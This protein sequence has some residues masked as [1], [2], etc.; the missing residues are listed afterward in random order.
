MLMVAKSPTSE[1]DPKAYAGVGATQKP[2]LASA[3]YE[4]P[5]YLIKGL[6]YYQDLRQYTPYYWEDRIRFELKSKSYLWEKGYFP[7][8]QKKRLQRGKKRTIIKADKFRQEHKTDSRYSVRYLGFYRN[9]AS[10]GR[11]SIVGLDSRPA[12][13]T[14]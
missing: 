6:G 7:H 1:G 5:K 13:L 9:R 12:W 8:A 11:S 3:I 10:G 2:G 14:N 4:I